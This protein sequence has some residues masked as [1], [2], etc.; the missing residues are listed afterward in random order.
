MLGTFDRKKDNSG[1]FKPNWGNILGKGAIVLTILAG[2]M[3]LTNPTREEYLNYASGRLITEAKEN[4]CNQSNVPEFLNGISGSLVD[5]CQS[6]FT[7]QRDWIQ[8]NINKATDRQNAI[9]FSVYTTDFD[10]V[11]KRYRTIGV[12]GNFLTF[13]S[14]SLEETKQ[15]EPVSK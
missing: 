8:N 12:L 5:A 14:E 6:L 4:W 7:N 9:L 2:T 1:G 10:F 3:S 15:I 11:D 13:S